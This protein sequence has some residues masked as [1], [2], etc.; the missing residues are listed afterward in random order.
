MVHRQKKTFRR[1]PSQ[2][3]QILF[4]L[5]KTLDYGGS[6]GYFLGFG[7][8]KETTVRRNLRRLTAE[9][10]VTRKPHRYDPRTFMYYLTRKGNR[11][12]WAGNVTFREVNA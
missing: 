10:F 1:N 4:N 3:Y 11:A 12:I 7:G 9:G 2:P 8:W 5:L 6:V